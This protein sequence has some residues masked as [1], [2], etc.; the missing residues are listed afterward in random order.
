MTK[1]V[2]ESLENIPDPT[3]AHGFTEKGWSP[4]AQT[5]LSCAGWG[6]EEGPAPVGLLARECVC[7]EASIR[8]SACLSAPL[9]VIV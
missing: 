3:V 9:S 7:V 4:G 6:Y 8:V 2:F 1:L 5:A